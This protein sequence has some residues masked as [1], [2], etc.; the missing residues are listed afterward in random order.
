MRS[1]LRALAICIFA[2]FEFA[3][4][5]NPALA[6][7]A[8]DMM[9]V[10]GTI[11]QSALVQATQAEWR[12]LP[13]ARL[14]CV[15]ETLRQRGISLQALIGDGIT[16][17]DSRISAVLMS[18]RSQADVQQFANTPLQPTTESTP[19]PSPELPQTIGQL[20]KY[21]VDKIPLG[22]II[23][24]ESANYKEYQCRPSDQ[25]SGLTWCQKQRTDRVPRGAYLSSSSILHTGDGRVFYLNR[26]LE[27]AFFDPGEANADIDRLSRAFGEQ[28]RSIAMPQRASGLTG[29]IAYWGGV[30]LGPLNES[31]TA[32]LASGRS[33]GGI[34]VDFAG[35]FQGSIRQS[36]PIYRVTGAAGFVWAESHDFAGRGRLRFFA[37]D[38]SSLSAPSP[39]TSKPSP[40]SVAAADPWN[41]CQSSDAETRLGGCTKVID[42][43]GLDRSRLADAFDG[44]CSAHNQMKQYQPALS[45]CKTAVDLNPKYS[46]A[47]ANLGETYLGLNDSSSALSALNNAVALKTNS[48]WSRLSRAKAFEAS[49][50]N[51]EALKDYQYA[52]LIDPTNQVAKDGATNLMTLMS[53]AP[54]SSSCLASFPPAG[55]VA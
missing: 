25:F 17:S 31:E 32:A 48:V 47:Y 24:F 16:P 54:A 5:T 18:C 45:D 39:G 41:D 12:K 23:Q 33:P 37:I 13:P 49:R 27:P 44:R 8:R 22:S 4:P 14:S 19:R 28:P 55:G 51:E 2:G 35:D 29:V 53:N 15:D 46:Y 9:N 6:Q 21:K 52:L 10:F 42:A 20:S 50:S 36:L 30:V 38:P 40:P 11:M 43:R 34:L 7:N 1:G 26:F 3:A